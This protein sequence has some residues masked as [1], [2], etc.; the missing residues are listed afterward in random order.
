MPLIKLS[1]NFQVTIPVSLRRGFDLKEG[2][3]LE[4]AVENGVFIFKP[5]RVIEKIPKPKV[6]KS[7]KN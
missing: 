1:K 2:D 3:Y 5:V 6:T 4:V 7:T